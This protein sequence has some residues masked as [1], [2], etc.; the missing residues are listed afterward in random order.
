[1]IR[2]LHVTNMEVIFVEINKRIY[3]LGEFIV[4]G[5]IILKCTLKLG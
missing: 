4:D 5:R 3:Y 1:M 2:A